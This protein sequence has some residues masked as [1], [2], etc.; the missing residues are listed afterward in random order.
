[1]SSL[2]NAAAFDKRGKRKFMKSQITKPTVTI[3]ISAYN[4]QYTIKSVIEQVLNQKQNGWKLRE[5]RIYTDGSSDNTVAVC[6][7][8]KDKRVVVIAGKTRKGK[9]YRWSE[10]FRD[11]TADILVMF[12]ADIALKNNQVISSLIKPLKAKGT[13]LVG[14]NSTPFP[15]ATF[16]EKA[17]YSTFEV[18]Y[19]SRKQ[20]RGGNNVFG[21]TGSIMAAKKEFLKPIRLPK[22]V[23]E[24]AYLY[25]AC[26]K[27]GHVF[28]YVDNA[29]IYYYLPKAT[30]DYIKQIM[31]S[32]PTA[33]ESELRIY[34]PQ[35]VEAELR[36]PKIAYY[37]NIFRA[38]ARNPL[39]VIYVTA[40][41]LLSK[42]FIGLVSRFYNLDWFTATSTKYSRE[43]QGVNLS[44]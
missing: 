29:I 5:V 43:Q 4:E 41:N 2:A 37:G 7:S 18:F 14:G 36:R 10:L 31:R 17:V 28:R 39:G 40:L 32:E 9:T 8:I 16:M 13:M 6:K 26:L 24:D 35:L 1:M 22:V 12:D 30:R 21:C 3:G 33:V 38:F 42:P 44:T 25:F 11:F 34:F 19:A 15:P 20:F 27:Q 23:N